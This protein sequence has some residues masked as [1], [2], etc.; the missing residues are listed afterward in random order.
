M[1]LLRHHFRSRVCRSAFPRAERTLPRRE[2][3]CRFVGAITPSGT[4]P[5]TTHRCAGTSLALFFWKC[6]QLWRPVP[7]VEGS[8]RDA[9][10]T[11]NPQLGQLVATSDES[12]R[13]RC[14]HLPGSAIA[15]VIGTLRRVASGE[16]LCRGT[17]WL[18]DPSLLEH[19]NN[20]VECLCVAASEA[21]ILVSAAPSRRLV[22][23]L[24][25]VEELRYTTRRVRRRDI[26]QSAG[27]MAGQQSSLVGPIARVDLRFEAISEVDGVE[28]SGAQVELV[29]ATSDPFVS[30][31][32]TRPSALVSERSWLPET[33]DRTIAA[34]DCD[35]CTRPDGTREI[36]APLRQYGASQWSSRLVALHD[37]CFGKS[38]SDMSR[39]STRRVRRVG[40][41]CRDDRPSLSEKATE[42]PHRR[43]ALCP[44]ITPDARREVI[45]ARG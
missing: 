14:V 30:Q 23:E 20:G 22:V 41:S 8:H 16:M 17:H 38:R 45:A 2:P 32:A 27:A 10:Q 24:S 39:E 13:H 29:V 43:D 40:W 4:S 44:H 26:S 33:I 18:R 6:A 15:K 19:C 12:G 9:G 37:E 21:G 28:W 11:R 34:V 3:T 36:T 35:A 42:P 7:V 5:A 1:S 25:D 31:C